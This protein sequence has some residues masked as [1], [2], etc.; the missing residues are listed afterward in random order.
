MRPSLRESEPQ[1]NCERVRHERR[2]RHAIQ[3]RERGCELPGAELQTSRVD[4]VFGLLHGRVRTTTA[5]ER[6]SSDTVLR[7][8]FDSSDDEDAPTPTEQWL[9][10]QAFG[11]YTEWRVGKGRP[12]W[13]AAAATI[14][15]CF[16]RFRGREEVELAACR[17]GEAAAEAR[18]GCVGE[19]GTMSV[20]D[21]LQYQYEAW[22]E[23]GEPL[24]ERRWYFYQGRYFEL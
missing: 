20:D 21:G 12:I 24:D 18:F 14:Q 23:A 17:A 16:R 2:M 5:P 15:R 19:Y 6:A 8:C 13:H 22:C 4:M 9:G 11:I 7:P 3:S 1:R 10:E